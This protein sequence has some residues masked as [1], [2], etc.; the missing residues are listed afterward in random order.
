MG[1]EEKERLR[2]YD[3]SR[4]VLGGEVERGGGRKRGGTERWMATRRDKNEE[5][6]STV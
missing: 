6:A 5:R 1:K 2:R 3:H 4:K